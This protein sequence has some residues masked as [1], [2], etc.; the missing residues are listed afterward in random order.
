[1]ARKVRDGRSDRGDRL[2]EDQRQRRRHRP[3]TPGWIVGQPAGDD[4]SEGD[5][6]AR[7]AAR[8]RD[9]VHRRRTGRGRRPRGHVSAFALDVAPDGLGVLTF[10]IPG[11]KVNKFSREVFV[12]L[13]EVLVRLSQDPRLR[14]LLVASGK[15]DVFIAGADIKEFTEMKPEDASAGSTRGQALFEQLARLPFPTV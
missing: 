13:S 1:M 14:A 15:P 6:P 4:A 3:R 5:A 11:E 9:D 8:P 10:D 12:E 2:G 7:R